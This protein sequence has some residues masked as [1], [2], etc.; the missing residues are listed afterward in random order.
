MD[1]DQ[2]GGRKVGLVI[3]TCHEYQRHQD[4]S[5][6]RERMRTELENLVH[7]AIL[8]RGVDLI[9]EEAS[10]KEQ[11]HAQLE[12]DE[13]RT[14]APF[15]VLF[16][17]TKVV[18]EPQETIARLIACE[19]LGDHYID[20]RP[21][22]A[23]PLPKDATEEAIANRDDEMMRI[24][25]EPLQRATSVLV[26]CGERHRQGLCKRLEQRGIRVK[27]QTFPPN[28]QPEE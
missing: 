6:E 8:E 7:I 11:V 3:G 9:A 28:L 26:I 23:S 25:E 13:A 27:Q 16:A 15:D 17:E 19:E 21:P 2:E 14:P 12:A 24:L 22:G 20:I 18:D 10:N 4:R 5:V 1:G